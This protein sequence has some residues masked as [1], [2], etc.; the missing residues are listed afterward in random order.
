MLY[1]Q[2]LRDLSL[3]HAKRDLQ[4]M[5]HIVEVIFV[6]LSIGSL[7]RFALFYRQKNLI[8][9]TMFGAVLRNEPI[10]VNIR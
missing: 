2:T 10:R 9:I 1:V 7:F 3:V 5:K 6:Q 4:G 8:F